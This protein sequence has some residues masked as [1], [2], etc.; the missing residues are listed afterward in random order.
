M[1]IRS[2]LVMAVVLTVAP[3]VSAQPAGPAPGGATVLDANSYW[4]Y[5]LTIR[6]PVVA[7]A[8]FS[9]NHCG[10]SIAWIT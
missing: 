3:V 5:H 6:P 7:A 2:C 10:R 8:R 1:R 4:R 9:G